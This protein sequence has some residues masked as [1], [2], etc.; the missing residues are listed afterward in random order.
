MNSLLTELLA[1]RETGLIKEIEKLEN[2]IIR[3]ENQADAECW[4]LK[5]DIRQTRFEADCKLIEEYEEGIRSGL[6]KEEILSSLV[7]GALHRIQATM[8]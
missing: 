3:M 2:R 1:R 5:D 6:P 4:L 7:N 8:Q